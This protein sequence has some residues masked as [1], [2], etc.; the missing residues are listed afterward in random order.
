MYSVYTMKLLLSENIIEH[1]IIIIIMHTINYRCSSIIRTSDCFELLLTRGVPVN[2]N[3]VR[4]L[5]KEH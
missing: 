1:A 5:D 4:K 3:S 2:N